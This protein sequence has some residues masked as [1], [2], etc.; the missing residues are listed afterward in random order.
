M[1]YHSNGDL[2][3]VYVL[4]QSCSVYG[5]LH[6]MPVLSCTPQEQICTGTEEDTTMPLATHLLQY[7]LTYS[8][9]VMGIGG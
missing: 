3:Y 6:C 7:V 9:A 1:N 2:K 8:K 5:A 4:K